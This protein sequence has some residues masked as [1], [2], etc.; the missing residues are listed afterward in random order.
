[1]SYRLKK[2]RAEW[3]AL[4]AST[5][6][7]TSGAPDSDPKGSLSPLHP[8]LLDSP[9]RAI[10]TQLQTASPSTS[11]DPEAVQQRMR[12][13]ATNLEFSVDQFAAGVHA[14]AT[15]REMG[16]RLAEKSLGDAA[17]VL[18]GKERER[19]AGG[20]GVDVME[21]LRGLAR[22]LNGGRR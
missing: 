11:T 18:E 5:T 20:R 1:M 13:I 2:E 14:L 17:G 4:I 9:Q 16:E 12:T 6:Q 15:T 10:L 22:V 21:G 7:A 3:D 19:R 8:D